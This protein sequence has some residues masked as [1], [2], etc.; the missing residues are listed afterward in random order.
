MTLHE[1]DSP[2][3]EV[4][5]PIS[6]G[7]VR[8][9]SETPALVYLGRLAEGSRPAQRAALETMARQLTH[10]VCDMHTMPWERLRYQHTAA[11]RRWLESRAAPATANRHLSALRG[12][13][14][15]AWRLG[16]MD[17]ETYQR[18]ID[19]E[20][21][22]GSRLPAG[23]GIASKEL[24]ALFRAA[25]NARHSAT[26]ARDSALLAVMYAA[27]MRRAEVVALDLD[28]YD[29]ATG[30]LRIVGKGNKERI[31]YATDGAAEAL[32]EWITHRGG[33][34][35]PLF[36]PIDKAGRVRVRRL[37]GQ[38]VYD[39][40]HGLVEAAGLASLSPHDMRRSFISDLLDGG[41]DLAVAQQLAGHASP[42]T[43]ARYDRR[44]ER[45]KRK[46]A[47]L[48]RVPYVRRES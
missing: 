4:V 11:M 24:H 37:T 39:R 22:K 34:P 28:S 7:V 21:V 29:P 15:E 5:E 12:V 40:L 19:V 23:R 20:G 18:A 45:A 17:A 35:G 33:E 26:A 2:A 48:L 9:A 36:C 1:S 44:G 38:A 10:G 42:V 43:T 47:E 32:A 13:L 27:G 31:G 46:A 30:A 14:H 8:I 41:A 6:E 25:A 16:L 3:L